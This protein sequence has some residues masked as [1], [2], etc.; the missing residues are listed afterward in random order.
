VNKRDENV[1]STHDLDA[2]PLAEADDKHEEAHYFIGRMMDEWHYPSEFRWNLNA[3]VQALRN[4]TFAL[5]STLADQPR[6]R[7]WYEGQQDAMRGDP[8]LRKFVEG[9]NIVVKKRNLLIK[10][11]MHIGVFKHRR[12]KIGMN[13]DV[14]VD[15]PSVVILAEHVPKFGLI[16]ENH[17]FIGEE[18]GVLRNWIAEDL[19]E[20]SVLE[21]CDE[22]WSKIGDVL[23]A[24]HTLVGWNSTPPPRH[25]HDISLCNLLTETDVDPSLPKKW[26]WC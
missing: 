1:R 18:Y 2:C 15:V 23:S 5:Q 21:L 3:F 22:A 8:L 26:D 9:R 17:P 19:G 13:I 16:S 20:G 14:P 24:A 4:V 7:S 11:T 6:F 12:Q 10:S 25:G